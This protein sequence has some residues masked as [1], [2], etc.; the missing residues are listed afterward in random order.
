[1]TSPH[2]L[3]RDPDY[4][5]AAW[6]GLLARRNDLYAAHSADFIAWRSVVAGLFYIGAPTSAAVAALWR[7]RCLKGEQ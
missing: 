2:G 6:C 7:D 3:V 1:M 4:W 5:M